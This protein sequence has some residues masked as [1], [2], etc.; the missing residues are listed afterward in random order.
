LRIALVVGA[1]LLAA[2]CAGRASSD[3]GSSRP[4]GTA[5]EI[6]VL[7]RGTG[8]PA[9]TA[10]LVCPDGGTLPRAGDA[11]R[12]LARLREPFKPVPKDIACTLIYGGPQVARV[13][14]SF[15]GRRVAATFNRTNGCEID[16]WNRVAFLFRTR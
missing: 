1:A 14:G 5:L 15:R 16:R 7:P 12:R 10:R 2:G 3:G 8:G 11:C 9:R 4:A 6:T 13:R